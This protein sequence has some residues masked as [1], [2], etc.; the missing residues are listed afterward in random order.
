ME[1]AGFQKS[2]P[3]PG[4]GCVSRGLTDGGDTEGGLSLLAAFGVSCTGVV[5][6]GAGQGK[7]QLPALGISCHGPGSKENDQR[8][9]RYHDYKEDERRRGVA[10]QGQLPTST[11]TGKTMLLP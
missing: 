3:P 6:L 8:H 4:F 2:L 1:R 9:R 7:G 11:S 10:Y 5:N